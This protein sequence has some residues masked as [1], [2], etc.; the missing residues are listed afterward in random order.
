MNNYTNIEIKRI[1][2]ESEYFLT[3]RY[4]REEFLEIYKKE[5]K[6][7]Y[8]T[9]LPLSLI[10]INIE[11]LSYL[12]LEHQDSIYHDLLNNFNRIITS[13]LRE[14]DVT[15]L[16]ANK[17][18]NIL[19]MDTSVDEAQIVKKK[20]T[21]QLLAYY[22]SSNSENCI[23]ILSKIKFN[24]IPLNMV[25]G[26]DKIEATPVYKLENELRENTNPKDESF[27]N[28]DPLFDF[29]L[30]ATPTELGIL[31]LDLPVSLNRSQNFSKLLKRFFDLLGALFGMSLFSPMFIIIA[32]AIKLSSKGPIFYKQERLGE[33]GKPF[34]LYK[35]RTM[36][37][38]SDDSSHR[39]YVKKM[40]NGNE[41]EINHGTSDNPLF[42]L[43]KDNRITKVGKILRKTSL[44]EV[45]QLIN[46]LKNEMSLVGPRPPLPYEVES[47]KSW[48]L[49]RIHEAKPGLTGLW[50]TSGKNRTT[51]EEMV[52]LDLQYIKK[53]STWLDMKIVFKTLPAMLNKEV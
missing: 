8:R 20:L 52:R 36:R 11:S 45:P 28:S 40:I 41:S 23:D 30:K 39:D 34:L 18:I 27:E 1:S 43:K 15:Y 38:D 50:Q 17:I 5:L 24:L 21:Q 10:T 49:H 48:H 19:L 32:T 12:E 4:S 25:S 47:Y 53:R 13:F 14:E 44:D 33:F 6:R 37:N 51:F 16:S 7:S 35:F 31:A 46:I 26:K 29:K 42:K 9:G 3:G 2:K 22:N